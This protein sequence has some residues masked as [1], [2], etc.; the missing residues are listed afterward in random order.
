MVAAGGCDG[1]VLGSEIDDD[2]GESNAAEESGML[3]PIVGLLSRKGW[4]WVER[5]SSA[6]W[7]TRLDSALEVRGIGDVS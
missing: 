4:E 3:K 6:T 2:D 7:W 1:G 5:C